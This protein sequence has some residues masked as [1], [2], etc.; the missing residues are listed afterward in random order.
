MRILIVGAGVA[1][2]TLAGLLH[3]QGHALCIV[4]RQS[5][6]A[7]LG[8]A[9]SLWPQGSRVLHAVGS[10]DRFKAESEPM[11]SYSLRDSRGRLIGSYDIPPA[12]S[13][14]GHIGTIPRSDFIALLQ[15]RLDGA[16]VRHGV[17]VE[18]L[19]DVENSV[20]VQFTDGSE[21]SF[22]LVIGAD[23]IHSRACGNFSSDVSRNTTRGGDVV[24][25]GAI[26]NSQA[27]VRHEN[28]GV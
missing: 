22:D 5:E 17:S 24:S 7:D 2:L 8:Y 19:C 16:P 11:L 9:L 27:R 14:C 15:Q 1:G 13:S 12:V 4:D 10:Y 20:D 26:L 23:G 21:A 3:R 25:G 18:R 6:D 28:G